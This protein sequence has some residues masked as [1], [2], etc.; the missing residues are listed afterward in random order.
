[1]NVNEA[2]N[3]MGLKRG[4]DEVEI[5]KTFRQLAK[6]YHPDLAGES[7]RSM[8]MRINEAYSVLMEQGTSVGCKL[9][10]TSIFNFKKA[11]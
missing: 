10:H 11:R 5:K 3:V 9:T 4:C 2:L 8:F 7:S 1:M 6:K